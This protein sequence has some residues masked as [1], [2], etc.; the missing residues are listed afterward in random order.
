VTITWSIG[1]ERS[2]KNDF[3][4]TRSLASKAAVPC[5]SSSRAACLRRSG[6]RPVRMTLAPSARARRAVSSPMPALPPMKTTVWPSSSEW[7]PQ[8]LGRLRFLR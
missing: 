4:E 7:K 8:W 1:D 6:L 5:A 2:W 3:R